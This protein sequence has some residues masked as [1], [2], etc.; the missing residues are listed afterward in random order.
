M[1]KSLARTVGFLAYAV[2]T[3]EMVFMVTP[4]ALY[5]YSAYAPLLS[6]PSRFLATAWLPAFF[7]LH[8]SAEIVPRIGGWTFQFGLVGF[9]VAALQVYYAKFRS[10]SVVRGGFYKLVRHPQ[11]FFLAVAGL[12]L[13]IVWPRFI[14]LIVYVNMLW[15]YYLLARSEEKRMQSR[16]GDAYSELVR[17]TS[18][19][20]PGEP[21]RHL[22]Q[23]LFGW[24]SSQRLKLVVI[25]C[26]SLVAV[27]GG[28]FG[29][30]QLSLR[31]ITHLS[32]PEQQIA[33]V[34]LLHTNKAQL[35]DLIQSAISDRDVQ[36]RLRRQDGWILVLAADRKGAV[37]HT[38]N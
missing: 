29:L 7:L 12:G 36:D 38:M 15:F 22:A 33:A 34:S 30:R 35:G 20:I 26:V 4:F 19:F 31:L 6:A 17:N 18:M 11:Y 10:R 24:I 23:M 1:L 37:V 25:Y 9:L 16:Y 13:L 3:L 21:G 2:I 5:Y 28:A 27:V 32:L 14:L 8:L